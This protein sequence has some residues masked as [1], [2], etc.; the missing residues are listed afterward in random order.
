MD[1]QKAGTWSASALIP[2]GSNAHVQ[3]G[4][5]RMGVR[6]LRWCEKNQ[7]VVAHK[8]T[9]ER[10]EGNEQRGRRRRVAD[11]GGGRW[12]EMLTRF[13]SCLKSGLE[14]MSK[15]GSPGRE[16]KEWEGCVH[17]RW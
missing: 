13:G 5:F 17:R 9:V 15:K 4:S 2:G 1:G 16:L 7:R 10:I 12:R 11:S 8:G 3:G 14:V 6:K